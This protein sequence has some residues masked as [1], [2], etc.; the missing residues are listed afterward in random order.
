[1]NLDWKWHQFDAKKPPHG[2][3]IVLQ[4]ADAH[5]RISYAIGMVD[6]QTGDVR[7]TA[8]E[9]ETGTLAVGWMPLPD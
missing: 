4:M 2:K 7:Y 8:R 5:N 3:R 9:E 1:M 6:G